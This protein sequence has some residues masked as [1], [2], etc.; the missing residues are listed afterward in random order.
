M[1]ISKRDLDIVSGRLQQCRK[2][3]ACYESFKQFSSDKEQL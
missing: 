2:K 1:E 3:G